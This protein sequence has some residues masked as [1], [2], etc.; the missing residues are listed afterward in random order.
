MHLPVK[1]NVRLY[2]STD[3]ILPATGENFKRPF[4]S[5]H[6]LMNLLFQ[7]IKESSDIHLTYRNR[8]GTRIAGD[9]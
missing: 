8:I 4:P 1:K 2:I 9:L 5:F 7:E 3:G 6:Y